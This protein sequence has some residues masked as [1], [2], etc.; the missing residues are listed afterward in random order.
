MCVARWLAA[1]TIRPLTSDECFSFPRP[2][3]SAAA[4]AGG[5]GRT[6]QGAPR[7]CATPRNALCPCLPSADAPLFIRVYVPT[8]HRLRPVHGPPVRRDGAAPGRRRGAPPP[9]AT[10]TRATT[11]GDCDFLFVLVSMCLCLLLSAECDCCGWV[12]RSKSCRGGCV[13]TALQCEV[14]KAA[15]ASETRQHHTGPRAPREFSADFFAN[16]VR[17]R[18]RIRYPCVRRCTAAPSPSAS[19]R[20]KPPSTLPGAL[21]LCCAPPACCA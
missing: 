14:A 2:F 10:I 13:A 19:R 5:A 20:R 16:R 21:L 7:P 17:I 1:V 3:V 12:G 11:G 6:A 8:G 15:T 18:I 4:S 9:R